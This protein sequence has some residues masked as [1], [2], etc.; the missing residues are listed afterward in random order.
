VVLIVILTHLTVAQRLF[1]AKLR[2]S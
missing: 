2:L 1:I